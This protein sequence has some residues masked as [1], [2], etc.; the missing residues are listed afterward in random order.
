MVTASANAVSDIKD[1]RLAGANMRESIT[2]SDI[3]ELVKSWMCGF[4]LCEMDKYKKEHHE[5]ISK[6]Y[7]ARKLIPA[8]E[9]VYND[10]GFM[11]ECIITTSLYCIMMIY[12]LIKVLLYRWICQKL[13]PGM[14][15]LTLTKVETL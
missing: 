5:E 4:V 8:P 14:V 10:V 7:L 6:L 1:F 12:L 11:V 13:Y 15:Y 2:A 3:K 9:R